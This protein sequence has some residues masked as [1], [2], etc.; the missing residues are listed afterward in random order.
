M[1]ILWVFLPILVMGVL[2]IGVVKLASRVRIWTPKRTSWVILI[3]FMFGIISFI[4]ILIMPNKTMNPLS[5]QQLQIALAEEKKVDE[6]YWA[7]KFDQIP[8]DYFV[9]ANSYEGTAEDIEITLG[10]NVYNT[11]VAVTWND[12]K[13][14]EIVATYYESPLIFNRMDISKEMQPPVIE[15]RD[16]HFYISE[17]EKRIEIYSVRAKVEMLDP[18]NMGFMPGEDLDDFIGNRILHLNVPKHF[19]IID[20]SGRVD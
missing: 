8:A 12:S 2:I 18:K 13:S 7:D 1:N 19:N 10:E 17:V 15:F 14:K 4:G 6:L 3:Y 16:N 20:N 11:R 9:F 5:E